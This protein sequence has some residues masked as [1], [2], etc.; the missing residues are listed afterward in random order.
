MT[1][2][3]WAE[4]RSKFE[5]ILNAWKNAEAEAREALSKAEA[6]LE[7]AQEEENEAVKNADLA[8]YNK[9]KQNQTNARGAIQM[10]T[11]RLKM[12]NDE[13]LISEDVFRK[14]VSE[15]NDEFAKEQAETREKLL[16]LAKQM[17][18]I[19]VKLGKMEEEA[20]STLTLI[21][22]QVYRCADAGGDPNS[23]LALVY[24][25]KVSVDETISYGT[26]RVNT[27]FYTKRRGELYHAESKLFFG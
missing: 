12:I 27:E 13:P 22:D 8:A 25:P 10:Y 11:K 6:D 14:A 4:N 1:K 20:N 5:G 9:A 17:Y 3:K 2:T 23:S 26:N 15:I 19:A 16:D 24:H 21:Y 7:Q 18:D